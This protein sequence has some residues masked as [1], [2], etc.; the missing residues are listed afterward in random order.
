M[1]IAL[2]LLGMWLVGHLVGRWAGEDRLRA[3]V[4]RYADE[5]ADSAGADALTGDMQLARE[6]LL[7]AQACCQALTRNAAR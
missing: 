5:L 3:R 2:G 4:Y 6:R 1:D 7:M